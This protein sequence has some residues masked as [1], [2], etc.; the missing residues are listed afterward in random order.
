MDWLPDLNRPIWVISPKLP[1]I[2]GWVL[3]TAI[4]GLLVWGICFAM[5][6][7]D[8][9]GHKKRHRQLEKRMRHAEHRIRQNRSAIAASTAPTIPESDPRL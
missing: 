2:T 1:A 9:D 3:L 5:N 8:H 4:I 6:K 7:H